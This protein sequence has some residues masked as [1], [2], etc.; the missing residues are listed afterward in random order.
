M[1]GGR[2]EEVDADETD[3]DHARKGL[4]GHMIRPRM[5]TFEECS[6]CD[7]GSGRLYLEVFDMLQSDAR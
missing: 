5:V 7:R 6:R 3:I 2:D 1:L 4:H